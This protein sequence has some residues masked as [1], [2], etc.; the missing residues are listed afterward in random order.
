PY[1]DRR[2]R[3]LRGWLGALKVC[4]RQQLRTAAA[5][6]QKTE[7]TEQAL[8]APGKL[9]EIA[10]EQFVRIFEPGKHFQGLLPTLRAFVRRRVG[11]RTGARR[12]TRCPRLV[13]AGIGIDEIGRGRARDALQRQRAQEHWQVIEVIR[14]HPTEAMN[15][16]LPRTPS[17]GQS[18]HRID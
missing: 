7:P 14:I 10:I 13:A 8:L 12:D 15:E 4:Y 18:E 11:A 16:V 17:A 5:F 9:R 3:L 1:V 2:D 6:S